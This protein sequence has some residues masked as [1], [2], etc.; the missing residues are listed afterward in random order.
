[1]YIYG[2]V[3]KYVHMKYHL[4]SGTG[5]MPLGNSTTVRKYV[6]VCVCEVTGVMVNHGTGLGL[7][8]LC[9]RWF[10]GHLAF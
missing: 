3:G 10:Y 6:C 1:M 7:E 2:L 9:V 4:H 5:N 8:I